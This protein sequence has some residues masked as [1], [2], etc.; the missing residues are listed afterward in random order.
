M[1]FF[2][3]VVWCGICDALRRTYGGE[4]WGCVFEGFEFG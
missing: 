1:R 2:W 4:R 3:G